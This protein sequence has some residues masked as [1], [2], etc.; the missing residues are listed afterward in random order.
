M[1]TLLL[2][3]YDVP[4]TVLGIYSHY[5]VGLISTKQSV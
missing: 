5:L 1:Y 4:G 2:S 3:T